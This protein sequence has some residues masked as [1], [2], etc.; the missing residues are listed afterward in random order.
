M[1]VGFL[2]EHPTWTRS[3]V[4]AIRARGIDIEPID[5]AT[6]RWRADQRP[7]TFDRWINRVNSMPSLG[8]SSSVVAAT[9]QLLAWLEMHDQFV[10]NGAAVHR[11]GSSKAAQGALF[12]KL[13]MHTPA[14]VSIADPADAAAAAEMLRLPVLTKP[15]VGGS[16]VGIQRFDRADDLAAASNVD[17]GMDGTGVVQQVIESADGF[18]YRVEMLGA[19]V[20]Y[21]TAQPLS[22]DGFN[23]CAV[24][25]GA[26]ENSGTTVQLVEPTASVARQ[27][28][29]FMAAAQADVGSVEYMIDAATGGPCFFDF[30]PYSN[31]IEGFDDELGFNPIER[32][33]DFVIGTGD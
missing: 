6:Y 12:S 3:L 20:L 26:A 14:S 33:I 15:N 1:K 25:G 16:G 24:D 17:L 2:Y 10:I 27:A 30:N 9:A 29:E 28:A 23:Y 18:V 5:V 4:E 21:V 8:R 31:F 11:I 32:Y 7:P 22:T 13:G 19:D